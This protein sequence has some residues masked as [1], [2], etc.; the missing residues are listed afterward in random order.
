MQVGLFTHTL[1]LRRRSGA[2]SS[3][4]ASWG[5]A[6]SLRYCSNNGINICSP[7]TLLLRQPVPAHLVTSLERQAG[8]PL[9]FDTANDAQRTAGPG[10][11]KVTELFISTYAHTA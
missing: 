11:D 6:L 10:V 5:I 4:L 3:R 2:Q 7:V 8:T 9:S 1:A